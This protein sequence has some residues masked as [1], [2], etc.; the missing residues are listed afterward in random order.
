VWEE[1]VGGESTLTP[2]KGH[3]I[4]LLD[5]LWRSGRLIGRKKEKDKYLSLQG[6]MN[7]TAHLIFNL[8]TS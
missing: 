7:L 2:I 8:A 6:C 5:E 3:F 4:R 1:S